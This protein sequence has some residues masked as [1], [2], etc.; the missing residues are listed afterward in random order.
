VMDDVTAR[1]LAEIR[2][3]LDG[4]QSRWRMEPRACYHVDR[5]K[6]GEEPWRVALSAG[7]DEFL[8]W[9]RYANPDENGDYLDGPGRGDFHGPEAALIMCAPDDL[10]FLLELVESGGWAP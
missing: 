3:R 5:I 10:R 8:G 1:R 6:A 2:E 4:F 9:E 7:Y